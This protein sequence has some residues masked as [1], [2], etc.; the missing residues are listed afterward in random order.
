MDWG[1]FNYAF[2]HKCSCYCYYYYYRYT[3]LWVIVFEKH[4]YINSE[5]NFILFLLAV[6]NEKFF[7]EY[8]RADKLRPYHCIKC[9]ARH[10]TKC[11]VLSHLETC[12]LTKEPVLQCNWCEFCA[13]H[14]TSLT[15]HT[16]KEHNVKLKGRPRRPRT[17]I[18]KCNLCA[19]TTR[20]G[21]LKRHFKA[22]HGKGIIE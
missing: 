15:F 10:S 1:D 14:W 16:Q 19:Y 12:G 20:F 21:N 4:I 2:L 11:A 8:I 6:K 7:Y 5:Y 13:K 18:T 9:N 3:G 17:K 22:T